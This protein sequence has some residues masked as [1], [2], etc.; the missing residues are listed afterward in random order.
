MV[1]P[2]YSAKPYLLGTILREIESKKVKKSI[3]SYKRHLGLLLRFPIPSPHIENSETITGTVRYT[4]YPGRLN[5]RNPIDHRWGW[6]FRVCSAH[7]HAIGSCQTH[8]K[9][10]SFESGPPRL[11]VWDGESPLRRIIP[12]TFLFPRYQDWGRREKQE[13]QAG[14]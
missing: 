2:G 9:I 14:R 8:L 7:W 3:T 6:V 1:T 10:W 11:P 5:P 12:R 4:V 13:V